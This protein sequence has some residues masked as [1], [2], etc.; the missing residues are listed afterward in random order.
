[1]QESSLGDALVYEPVTSE[2]ARNRETSKSEK[3]DLTAALIDSG[4]NLIIVDSTPRLF[5]YYNPITKRNISPMQFN[6]VNLTHIVDA[7]IIDFPQ[8]TSTSIKWELKYLFRDMADAVLNVESSNFNPLTDDIYPRVAT[9]DGQPT[10]HFNTYNKEYRPITNTIV[11]VTERD[12]LVGNVL[13]NAVKFSARSIAGHSV[14]GENSEDTLYK[15]IMSTFSAFAQPIHK[16]MRYA[17][18]ILGKQGSG[19]S[20]VANLIANAGGYAEYMSVNKLTGQFASRWDKSCTVVVDEATIENENQANM[21]KNFL[22]A[23]STDLEEKYK[24][25]VSAV[26]YM[27]F[28]FTTNQISDFRTFEAESRRYFVLTAD[29]ES[30][31]DNHDCITPR[32]KVT[33]AE[34]KALNDIR[35]ND[36][37]VGNQG[38]VHGFKK[39]G[40]SDEKVAGTH[41]IVL[42][43]L[44]EI[45]SKPNEYK[46][47]FKVFAEKLSRDIMPD[48]NLEQLANRENTLG[49]IE[50]AE[51]VPKQ[52]RVSEEHGI[53]ESYLTDFF[54]R[55]IQRD[56]EVV[57]DKYV[58]LNKAFGRANI[59]KI[60]TEVMD[61]FSTKFIWNGIKW[62]ILV[63]DGTS[64]LIPVESRKQD[65]AI[66]VTMCREASEH[67]N[68]LESAQ[69][70]ADEVV[71]MKAKEEVSTKVGTDTDTLLADLAKLFPDGGRVDIIEFFDKHTTV[72][73]RRASE[74]VPKMA[75]VRIS[76]SDNTIVY[77]K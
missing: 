50:L 8:E 67:H 68:K 14:V 13:Y 60:P 7:L 64:L 51:N 28:I 34:Y 65:S 5:G 47:A 76:R 40:A 30:I 77:T 4:A 16:R 3:A 37:L 53:I 62:S 1:M 75:N 20:I 44:G 25:N 18:V 24:S 9:R 56:D 41:V 55:K 19:K 43:Q 10:I 69:V 32:V 22:T 59:R 29:G 17:P 52:L 21:L 45:A 38:G 74:L 57:N 27:N 12:K 6:E 66:G 26:L 70:M 48:A 42:S 46:G 39:S 36:F 11:K 72:K 33:A 63:N 54:I 15:Q 35:E 71:A 58:N 23:G 31:N 2:D 73:R 49:Q 61:Y